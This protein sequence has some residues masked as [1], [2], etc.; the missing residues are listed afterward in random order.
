MQAKYY[1][2]YLFAVSTYFSSPQRV[3]AGKRLHKAAAL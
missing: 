2:D 3:H 1:T